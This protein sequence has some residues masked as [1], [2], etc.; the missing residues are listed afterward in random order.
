MVILCAVK[1][2][3]PDFVLGRGEGC[4]RREFMVGKALWFDFMVI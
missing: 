3:T 2:S 4:I 1:N